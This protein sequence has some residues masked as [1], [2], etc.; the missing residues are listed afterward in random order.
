MGVEPSCSLSSPFPPN[1]HMVTNTEALWTL[2]SW[3]FME[4]SLHRHVW[5]NHWPLVTDS[6][7]RPPPLCRGGEGAKS[8]NVLIRWLV[9]LTAIPYE[10]QHLLEYKKARKFQKNIY[11]CFIDYAKAFWH[12]GSNYRKFLKRWEYQTTLPA[13]W[14]IG[15]QV[16]KKQLKLDMENRLVPNWERSTSMLNTVTLLI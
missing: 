10:C 6:M 11:F 14:E 15:M 9:L 13:S 1:R 8:S 2:S 12:C 3:V 5:L 7:S 16:K 4:A